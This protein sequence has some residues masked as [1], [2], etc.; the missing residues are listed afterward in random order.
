[1]RTATVSNQISRERPANNNN[2]NTLHKQFFR[3]CKSYLTSYFRQT[4][5]AKGIPTTSVPVSASLI[6]LD[7]GTTLHLDSQSYSDYH[8]TNERDYDM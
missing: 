1:M 5:V 8:F 4:S 3:Y 2:L 6:K 7:A